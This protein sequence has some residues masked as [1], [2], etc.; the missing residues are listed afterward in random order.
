[1]YKW[2]ISCNENAKNVAWWNELPEFDHNELMGWSSHPIEKPY[3]LVEL[4]SKLEHPRVQKRFE[5]G[6]RLL[7]GR[8]PTPNVI[9]VQGKTLL[10]QLV[11]ALAFGDF[12]TM[13]L[14]L[15]NNVNPGTS[16]IVEKFK[17]QLS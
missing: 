14:A 12:V 13:Y 5:V 16:D 15:L 9:E 8:R 6:E 10:D 17:K 4:R 3:A 1:A 7:S 2:K 11:W